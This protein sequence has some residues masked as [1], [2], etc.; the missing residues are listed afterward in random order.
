MDS[1]MREK[2]SFSAE[3]VVSASRDRDAQDKEQSNKRANSEFETPRK[4]KD[5]DPEEAESD[6][7]FLYCSLRTE[8]TGP[9]ICAID[10]YLE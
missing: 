1:E 5:E 3:E 10:R 6:V 7:S 9:D 4:R 2:S 8:L